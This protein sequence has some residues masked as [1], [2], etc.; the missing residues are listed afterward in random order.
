MDSTLLQNR[1]S[2]HPENSKKFNHGNG[3]VIGHQWTNTHST[4]FSG[5]EVQGHTDTR[6][7]SGFA[8]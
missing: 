5:S 7:T 8:G 4:E 1:S 2:L 6:L 3:F